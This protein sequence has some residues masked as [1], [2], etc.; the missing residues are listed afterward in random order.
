MTELSTGNGHDRTGGLAPPVPRPKDLTGAL[1]QRRARA[2]QRDRDATTARAAI[3][4]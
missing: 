1:R 4:L 2:R 3:K